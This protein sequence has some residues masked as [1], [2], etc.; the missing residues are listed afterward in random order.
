MDQKSKLSA[1][2]EMSSAQSK[3]FGSSIREQERNE[4][5]IPKIWERE[6]KE[7]IIPKVR[8]KSIPTFREKESEAIIPGNPPSSC[9]CHSHY[10]QKM[11]LF[12]IT[13]TALQHKYL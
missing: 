8:E 2:H 10:Q 6:G 5:N 9:H 13:D 3:D 12:T 4:K 11:I 1:I 7:K